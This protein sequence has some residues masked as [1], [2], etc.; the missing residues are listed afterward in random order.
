M[1]V[2]LINVVISVFLQAM[3]CTLRGVYGLL[4]ACKHVLFLA[5]GSIAHVYPAFK[6]G[7][8]TRAIMGYSRVWS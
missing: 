7:L 3:A 4:P 5:L 2:V 8:I 6:L 1:D